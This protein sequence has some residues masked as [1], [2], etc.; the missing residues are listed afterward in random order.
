MGACSTNTQH[1]ERLPGCALAD[2]GRSV[3]MQLW[4]ASGPVK[5]DNATERTALERWPAGCASLATFLARRVSNGYPG[6]NDPR[7][8]LV[9]HIDA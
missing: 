4:S 2:E 3:F 7:G 1:V 8:G 5:P 6:T 9:R